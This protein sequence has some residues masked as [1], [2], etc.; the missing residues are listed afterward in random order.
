MPRAELHK[1]G[2]WV[3]RFYVESKANILAMH[4]LREYST[5]Q[6]RVAQDEG[7]LGDRK[8]LQIS[9]YINANI[10]QDIQLADLAQLVGI[11]QFHFS[12]LFKQSMKVAAARRACQ[13]VTQNNKIFCRRS[14]TVWLQSSQSFEQAIS[15]A[16]RDDTQ[17]LPSNLNLLGLCRRV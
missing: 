10:D 5:T 9:E 6:P 7:A 11:S 3:G 2:G 1:G 4:L 16:N 15:P 14:F 8:L 17:N 12:C 13:A